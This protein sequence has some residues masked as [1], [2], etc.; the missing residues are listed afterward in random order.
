MLLLP[1]PDPL[2]L[3]AA[4]VSPAVRIE[5]KGGVNDEMQRSAARPWRLYVGG[6]RWVK[7]ATVA[8]LHDKSRFLLA[9]TP[10]GTIRA[11]AAQATHET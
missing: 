4:F 5:S 9:L 1:A 6:S 10:C 11:H 7:G 2:C 8:Y 3:E